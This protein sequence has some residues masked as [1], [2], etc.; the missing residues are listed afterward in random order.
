MFRRSKGASSPLTND[1]MIEQQIIQ[2]GITT[3]ILLDAFRQTDRREFV[4]EGQLASAYLDQPVPL[5]PGATV[6]QPYIVALMTELLRTGPGQRVLEIG[7]GSGYQAAILSLLA[8]SIYCVEIQP[9]LVEFS[10]QTLRRLGRNNIMII[11]G[12]GWD[13]YPAA[14]PYDRIIVTAAPD[15]VPQQLLHQL[16]P[17]GR[18]IAPIGAGPVQQL[19]VFDKSVTGE[20]SRSNH[21]PVQFVPLLRNSPPPI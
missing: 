6:S 3:P 13:G 21:S 7:S 9:E 14:A 4:P 16:R 15:S 18:M 19:E 17:G 11:A 20:V 8:E 2:R 10:R 5:M 12:N 1:E